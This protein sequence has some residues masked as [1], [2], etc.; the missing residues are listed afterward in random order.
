MRLRQRVS[1]KWLV[2]AA[3][4]VALA[5]PAL[6]LSSAAFTA[7][8]APVVQALPSADQQKLQAALARLGRDPRDV[9]ALIDAG[10]AARKLGDF[11]AAIGFYR[12]AD[13]I[14]GG[15]ARIKAGLAA[16]LAQSGDP[17]AALPL[18]AEAERAGASTAQLAADRGLAY[19]LVGDNAAA[20]RYY[21]LAIG[22]VNDEE[23][24]MRLAISQAIAGDAKASEATI[25][26]LL[27]KQDKP[28]WR[29]R[30]FSL[31]IAGDTKQAVEVSNTILPPQLAQN[32]A[33]YLRYMPRLTRAQQ[34]A[35]AN[36]GK[37]PRASEIGNDD[38]RIAAYRPQQIARADAN[39]VP[40]GEALGSGSSAA[41]ARPA[42]T[43][44]NTKKGGSRT[45]A[46][47]ASA[48]A[49]GSYRLGAGRANSARTTA[50]S[51]GAEPARVAPPEPM[52]TIERGAAATGELPP[53][54][55]KPAVSAASQAVA[56]PAPIASAS[57]R[58]L[59][60]AT[61]TS[62]AQT[63]TAQT[64]TVPPSTGPTSTAPAAPA[65]V[66]G[67]LAQAVPAKPT[68]AEAPP[69]PSAQQLSLEQIFADL[70]K[71][72]MQIMLAVGAVDIRQIEP[73]RPPAPK[74]EAPKPDPEAPKPAEKP[75]AKADP[76]AKSNAKANAKSVEDEEAA[77][78]KAAK[79][80]TKAEIAKAKAEAA[81]AK[82]PAP[83]SHPSRIWVQIGVG[84]N[85]AAIAFDWRRYTKQSPALFKGREVYVSEMGRTNRMLVGPF[86]TQKAASAFMADARKQGFSD[87]L[88]WTSPAGQ[89]VDPLSAD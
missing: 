36:L 67:T 68:V 29:T 33:P 60:V 49:T 74:I 85:K 23:V 31:A 70:G 88:P 64:S 61:P 10:D 59:P 62:T 89:V 2:S 41:A 57:S 65:R 19:D 66:G 77:A 82:K 39:L 43:S 1:S 12:R 72:T 87:A 52:P 42:K 45:G 11:D 14:S 25:M 37:F 7:S 84:R 81:K 46:R 21:M 58:A 63:S 8:A 48:P 3:T 18:F 5:V 17:V 28:G 40:R 35:A 69:E 73:A 26:P 54:Q 32:I 79:P 38:A 22:G 76:K 34:A 71:P 44:A 13:E 75:A 27:R 30:A 53:I 83:P 9:S 4:S 78:G 47:V 80:R 20:Q 55:A 6:A 86:A 51:A 56:S 50:P 15:N 24:R 16:S